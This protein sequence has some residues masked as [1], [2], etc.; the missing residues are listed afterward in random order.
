M[1]ELI[2]QSEFKGEEMDARFAA[3]AQLAAALEALTTVVAQKYV[4]PASGIPSTD[5][6]ADVQAALAKANT[7]VQSLADYYTKSEVDQMLAAINGMDY[8]DV[9]TLPTASA[10]TMGKIYLLGPD[11]SGYYAY[12]YTSYDGSAYSWVGPLGTTQ[13]SLANYATKDEL[14][15]K[16]SI[17]EDLV[18][19]SNYGLRPYTISGG[20]AY[21]VSSGYE[22]IVIPLAGVTK[23]RLKAKS[24]QAAMIAWLAS[25]TKPT[26]GGTVPYAPGYSARIDITANTEAQ[27][28]VPTGANWLFVYLG[29]A[30]ENNWAPDYLYLSRMVGEGVLSTMNTTALSSK[31]GKRI[32]DQALAPDVVDVANLQTEGGRIVDGAWNNTARYKHVIIPVTERDVVH[33]EANSQIPTSYAFLTADVAPSNS[34]PVPFVPNT[35]QSTVAVCTASDITVPDLAKFMYIYVGDANS[36]STMKEGVPSKVIVYHTMA[37]AKKAIAD[38]SRA[39]VGVVASF[40][41]ADIS[42]ARSGKVYGFV[43]G[44]TYRVNFLNPNVP[45]ADTSGSNYRFQLGAYDSEDTLLGYLLG[46][47]TNSSLPDYAD[48]VIP[49]GTAYLQTQGRCSAGYSCPVSFFPVSSSVIS[50]NVLD[51]NPESEFRPKFMSATKRYYTTSDA[52]QPSPLVILHLSDIH[53]NWD[54]VARFLQFKSKYASFIDAAL[55]TGDIADD[56][57]T[58]GVTGYTDIATDVMTVIGNHDTRGASGWQDYAGKEAYD[59]LIAPNVVN[60]G[61]TQPSD[62][63]TAGK[64]YYYKDFSEKH[65]RLVVVDIM[66]YDSTED[67]WLADVLASAKSSNFHVV[68]ATH[69]AGARAQAEAEQPVFTKMPCNYTTLYEMGGDSSLLTAYN[70]NAYMMGATVDAFITGGGKFVGYVQGHFHAD[71]VAKV[72]K[73]PNQLIYA[74]GA[75]KAGEMRDFNHVI[76]TRNQDEFQIVSIDTHDTI[77][78]LY[79]VGAFY[80]RYGRSKGSVCVNYSTGEVLG[81]GR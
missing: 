78:K 19:L 23:I 44:Q 32:N 34:Q 37:A 63:A 27:Y 13:I 65:L 50:G 16:A 69:F 4:K 8:V 75:S 28:D 26:S 14:S 41:G 71:F 25:N 43:P 55:C 64:C 38:V 60:W 6:D 57:L 21:G 74:I 39:D 3:V 18:N 29:T 61:V 58:D 48:V 40:D 73:Y 7:A 47:G 80:D 12:Y 53:A 79:K 46:W 51:N 30:G 1:P 5:M 15:Q 70:G 49:A 68:I 56:K 67:A 22:H 76:G 66:A 54:N 52:S 17:V 11:A 2:Y 10:S 42:L 33:V 77:V 20:G 45:L 9:S 72:A 59:A 62:A 31:E 36:T 35:Q 24:S 81:E